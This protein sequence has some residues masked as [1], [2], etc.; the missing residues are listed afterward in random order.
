M[1]DMGELASALERKAP[2]SSC[3]A[4]NKN[5][6][7]LPVRPAFVQAIGEDGGLEIGEGMEV[8]P[9]ICTQ[10]GYVRMHV[11]DFLE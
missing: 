6:W 7:T 11:V 8:V 9:V 4:C 2:V 1:P 5:E 3:P 10:C